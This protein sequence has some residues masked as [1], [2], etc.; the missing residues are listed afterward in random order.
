MK[1][2]SRTFVAI[3]ACLSGITVVLSGVAFSV[4]RMAP[5]ITAVTSRRPAGVDERLGRLR[6]ALPGLGGEFGGGGY[7]DEK[8]GARA[9]P[10]DDIPLERLTN[11]RRAFEELEARGS[12][13]GGPAGWEFLG[14]TSAVYQQTFYRFSYVPRQYESSG[15]ITAM[16]IAPTCGPGNCRIWIAAAG[17][18]VWRTDNALSGSPRWDYLSGSIGINAVG[19]IVLDPTDAS[20]QTMWI[21]TGEANASGDSAA[22]VG[23]YRSTDGGNSWSGPFGGAHFSGRAAGSIAVDPTNPSIIYV[24]TTRAVRG[25]SSVGGATATIPGAQP[26]GLWKT[27]DGGAS[28]TFLHNGAPTAAQCF[29]VITAACSGQ[30]VRRVVLD[31]VDPS[32]VYAGSYAR[33]VWRSP[34]GGSTWV[35]IK[36]S[37]LSLDTAMRPEIAV[38]TLP[39]G[40]T[41][42]YVGEGSS[43]GTVIVGGQP[44]PRHSRLFRS[45]DVATGMPTFVD[46]TSPD[47]AQPGFGSF[48]YCTGQCW[49]DNLV[50]TPPGYPDLVY[51]GGS[52]QYGEPAGISN[53]RALILSTD[54]G[55]SFTDM[56]KDTTATF[57]PNG[58][59]PD[60]HAIVLRPGNPFQFFS[61]SDGGVMRSSGDFR[62]ASTEC[63]WRTLDDVRRARCRQLLSRVPR[64]LQAINRGLATLQFQSLSVDPTNPHHVMGGTQDNGTFQTSGSTAYWKQTMWGDGGQSGFDVALNTFRFHT[65][66]GA[67]PDV[68]FESGAIHDWN[69]IGDRLL[70]EPQLFYPPLISDPAVSGTML[71]GLGHVWRTKTHG[72]GGLALPDFRGR[73]NEFTGDFTIYCGDWEPLGAQ[74]YN[75][76]AAPPNPWVPPPNPDAATRLTASGTLYGTDRAGG[77]V[78]YVARAAQDASTLWAATS[79]GRVFISKNGDAPASGVVFTR[80][81]PTASN[82]PNRFVTSIFVDPDNANRAWISYSGFN[83]ATPALPGHVFEVVYNPGTAT[84]TWTNLDGTGAGFIGD[85]PVTSV[86]FDALTGDLY[87]STDFGVARRTAGSNDWTLAAPGMPKVEVSAL[88]LVTGARRLY[89]ATHGLSAWVLTLP[90]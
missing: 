84:A 78:S 67:S 10:D 74:G 38:T 59:H 42:M 27:S 22:G 37:L 79:P 90:E 68:N 28:W 25:V 30:G 35:Q 18:G 26:Q 17:G 15:R 7:S 60:H 65:F 4:A 66:F 1:R 70:L 43:G 41:R 52:Y 9:Y 48:D 86:V 36:P 44:F 88:T 32:I 39:N 72:T 50:Y 33:G 34:D 63:D 53:G 81:D 58:L 83:A 57:Y 51:V 31:P 56:T 24:A 13:S 3:A 71:A 62:N 64:Q 89:A 61:G 47:P 40:K 20:G 76:P 80:I 46:L 55:V 29:P 23:V 6:Q 19:S 85:L 11:A 75:P 45:D 73:C 12:G 49:Y 21:G 5:D 77:A 87:A 69:W 8:F 16:A 54:A 14:P 2:S 82:D